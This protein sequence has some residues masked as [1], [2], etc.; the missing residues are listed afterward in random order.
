MQLR[1]NFP[2][3]FSLIAQINRKRAETVDVLREGAEFLLSA[4]PPE[5]IITKR[6]E[7]TIRVEKLNEETRELQQ[8]A[9]RI[10]VQ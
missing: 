8:K 7:R 10:K 9:E 3:Y 5:V 4:E 1:G 6:N 2:Q